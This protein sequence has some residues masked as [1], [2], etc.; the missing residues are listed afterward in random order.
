MP[1]NTSQQ[2]FFIVH[3]KIKTV[4]KPLVELW[5]FWTSTNQIGHGV[6]YMMICFA[7]LYHLQWLQLLGMAQLA[8]WI[9]GMATGTDG[10]VFWKEKWIT[11]GRKLRSLFTFPLLSFQQIFESDEI[12]KPSCWDGCNAVEVTEMSHVLSIA[13]GHV[14]DPYRSFCYDTPTALWETAARKQSMRL[15]GLTSVKKSEIT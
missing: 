10:C 6:L 1:E 7:N 14:P 2:D 5:E 9:L 11:N 3:S 15:G 13:G 8:S 4:K 12:L